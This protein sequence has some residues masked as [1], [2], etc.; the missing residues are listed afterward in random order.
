MGFDVQANLIG[1]AVALVFAAVMITAAVLSLSGR[2]F[3]AVDKNPL[4]ALDH[5][6]AERDTW[7]IYEQHEEVPEKLEGQQGPYLLEL[8]DGSTRTYFGKL[9]GM[10]G[11]MK[12]FLKRL[13]KRSRRP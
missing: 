9:E 11:S 8:P 12:R 3:S 4:R 7:T 13:P 1:I 10:D 2:F 6:R 5:L